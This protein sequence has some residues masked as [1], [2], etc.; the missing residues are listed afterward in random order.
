MK[1]LELYYADL[2]KWY[3]YRNDIV[4][5]VK[6]E[7]EI[8][9]VEAFID[10]PFLNH[11]GDVLTMD[12]FKPTHRN[13]YEKLP[14]LIYV[15]GGSLVAGKKRAA[16]DFC[17]LFAKLGYLVFSLE[18]RLAPEVRVYDELHDLC[19]GM[20][21]AAKLI[22]EH[23]GSFSKVFLGGES[24]GGF[25]ALYTAALQ[26]NPEMQQAIGCQAPVL[27]IKGLGLI[28]P[29]IYTTHFDTVGIFIQGLAYGRGERHKAFKPFKNPAAEDFISK[30]P[31][32]YLTTGKADLMEKQILKYACE[33]EKAKKDFTLNHWGEDPK[34]FHAFPVVRPFDPAS[35]RMMHEL[36]RWFRKIS[37]DIEPI[38]EKRRDDM[39]LR[40]ATADDL[41]TMKRIADEGKNFL[42]QCGVYQWQVGDYPSRSVYEQDIEKKQSYVLCKNGEVVAVAALILGE[43]PSY[44]TIAGKWLSESGKTYATIH[45]CAVSDTVRGQGVIGILFEKC[46]TIAKSLGAM[47]LRI[48]TH[49]DNKAMQRAL[50]KSG[51][52]C[53][54]IITLAEGLEI[55]QTRLAYEKILDQ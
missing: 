12:L 38:V 20:D 4:S 5:K 47:S 35:G 10:I 18:Y 37:E 34:L 27:K 22:A 51:V 31:P 3:L 25:L 52:I 32:I 19:A 28:S 48:D 43:D 23:D 42:K 46:A 26:N 11:S 24:A 40:E 9:G 14:V 44:S 13:D 8:D 7:I 17:K 16:A 21:H 41:P 53:C 29:M 2:V 39:I 33:L 30:L 45:R 1:S 50:E 36:D 55:G 6:N 15:H 54:G 49:K